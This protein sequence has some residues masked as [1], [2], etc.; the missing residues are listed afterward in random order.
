MRRSALFAF[1]VSL[2]VGLGSLPALPAEAQLSKG[3]LRLSIDDD[4]LSVAGV[5]VGGGKDT[6]VGFG[7]NQLGGS[8]IIGG[9]T[10]LGLGVGYV[11]DP[12]ILLGVR[13]GLGYDVIAP[14]GPGNNTRVLG[15]SLMPEVTFV[16]LGQRAKLFFS[17][18]PIFQVGRAR[19][20][21]R[22]DRTILGGFGL[23]VGTFIFVTNALSVDLGFHF[24]GRFGGTK[25]DVDNDSTAV[26]DLRGLLRL[27]VSLWT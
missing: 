6:V 17:F 20:D 24:E 23:G 9:P 13:V 26:Q 22:T 10:P 16:P 7:P 11:L 8:R 19:T 1:V 2:F 27:G 4:I 25:R 14:D 15:L 3:N 5:K 12:K 18:A 21:P